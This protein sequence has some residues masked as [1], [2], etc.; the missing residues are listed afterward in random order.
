LPNPFW[1]IIGQILVDDILCAEV[2]I[3]L[4]LGVVRNCVDGLSHVT[5]W[6][7]LSVEDLA[8]CCN[9]KLHKVVLW[10]MYESSPKI[11]VATIKQL[12]QLKQ[13]KIY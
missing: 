11:E 1:A 6:L 13:E 12:W 7:G 3:R 9:D 5:I 10:M 2:L 8:P 4:G